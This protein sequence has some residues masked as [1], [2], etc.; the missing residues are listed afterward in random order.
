MAQQPRCRADASYRLLGQRTR[1][2]EPIMRGLVA[3]RRTTAYRRGD[4]RRPAH[5]LWWTSS[6]GAFAVVFVLLVPPTYAVGPQIRVGPPFVGTPFT[7][8]HTTLSGCHTHTRILLAPAFN[9]T[10]GRVAFRGEAG[11][12]NCSSTWSTTAVVEAR[13]G[14]SGGSFVAATTGARTLYVFWNVSY[15]GNLTVVNR[16]YCNYCYAVASLSEVAQLNDTT[17]RSNVQN[18]SQWSGLWNWS[19]PT[20]SGAHTVLYSVRGSFVLFQIN[21]HLV[22]GHAYSFWTYLVAHLE[23]GIRGG[24][25]FTH[26]TMTLAGTRLVAFVR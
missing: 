11:A 26:A 1:T 4:G 18:L 20:N 12:G 2:R 22:K 19:G 7:S 10:T 21:A 23:S 17:N 13:I 3:G 9:L 5:R 25:G 14:L 8:V 16:S 15:A 6:L 24:A